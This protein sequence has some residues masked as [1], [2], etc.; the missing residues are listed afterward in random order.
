M[1]QTRRL[2]MIGFWLAAWQMASLLIGNSIIMVGPVDVIRSFS[3]LLPAPAFWQSIANSIGKISLGFLLAFF[4]GVLLGVLAYARSFLRDFLEP[5]VLLMKSVPVASFIILALIW[6]GSKNLAVF[7]SCVVVFP[8][9]YTSTIAGLQSTDRKLLEMAQV[10]SIPLRKRIR[11]IYLPALLPYLSSSCATAL[12]MAWKSGIAA[13]VI[14]VPAHTIGEHLY[15]AKVYL[16]TA[17]L[18]AWTIVI[19]LVSALFEKVFLLALYCID[20]GKR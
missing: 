1:K 7:A 11:Y 4:T 10:F 5:A 19:I 12:G 16:S 17:D 15:L 8:M 3:V 18:F 14:G 2:L 13:E 9:I 6:I 20:S